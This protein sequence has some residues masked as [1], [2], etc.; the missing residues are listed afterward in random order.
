MNYG[1]VVDSGCDLKHLCTQAN[2]PIDFT[3]VPLSLDIGNKVFAD[4]INL[5]VKS[6]MEEMYAYKGKTGSAAPSPEVFLKAYEKSNHVFVIT[7]TG[8][9]SASYSSACIAGDLFRKYYPDRNIHLIN[10]KSAGPQ[11]TLIVRKIAALIEQGLSFDEIVTEINAYQRQTHLLFVLRTLDNLVKNGR[12]SKLKAKMAGILGIK[13][14]GEATK[15]GIIAIIEQC[16]GKTIAYNR[17][18]E[19]LPSYHYA[20]GK[21]VIAHCFAED[22][23]QSLAD[24]ITSIYPGCEIELMPTSGLCSYY[25]EQGGI[26]IG[27]DEQP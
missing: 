10:S 23:A 12:V 8:S 4:D 26:L 19:L 21:V 13:I 25:A 7:V 22:I 18:V 2:T 6:Y 17:V 14:I 5:D 3:R 9:L 27:F 1:I 20:G 15:E 16:R 24:S 11:M